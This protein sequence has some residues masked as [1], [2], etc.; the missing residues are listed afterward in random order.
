MYIYVYVYIYI[1]IYMINWQHDRKSRLENQICKSSQKMYTPTTP[2]W[3][4]N[5]NLLKKNVRL[6]Y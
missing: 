4:R 6:D 5:L 2:L 1:Y 3:M